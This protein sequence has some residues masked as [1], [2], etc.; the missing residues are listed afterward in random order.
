[1]LLNL[2]LHIFDVQ[3]V[4]GAYVFARRS[5]NNSSAQDHVSEITNFITQ[6]LDFLAYGES[7]VAKNLNRTSFHVRQMVKIQDHISTSMG[8]F[9]VHF[10]AQFHR[11]PNNQDIQ[12]WVI[13]F[14]NN[15]QKE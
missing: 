13:S 10:V 11:F 2:T 15:V 5:G 4:Q 9:S 3:R 7:S 14:L 6:F 1:M 12:E 8:G